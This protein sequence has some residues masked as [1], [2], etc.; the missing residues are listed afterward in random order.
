[1]LMA[2]VVAVGL[3]ATI[4]DT[5]ALPVHVFLSVAV[6]ENGNVPDAVGVPASRPV[7]G[8]IINHDGA[9]VVDHPSGVAP[10]E[11]ENCCEYATPNVAGDKVPDGDTVIAGQPEA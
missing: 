11:A 1:M 9:P 10:P 8:P 6:T 3:G 7:V 5:L 4:K 2:V